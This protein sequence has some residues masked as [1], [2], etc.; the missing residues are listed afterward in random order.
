MIIFM[1]ILY[2]NRNFTVQQAEPAPH[3]LL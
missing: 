2:V 3:N 1:K